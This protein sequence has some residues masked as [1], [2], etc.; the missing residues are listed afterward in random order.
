[1]KK[2]S[3]QYQLFIFLLFSSYFVQA[4]TSN[5]FTNLDISTLSGFSRDLE[6]GCEGGCFSPGDEVSFYV[7]TRLYSGDPS[8]ICPNLPNSFGLTD[9]SYVLNIGE[10]DIIRLN[11][12]RA[13]GTFTSEST[14]NGG[15]F[16][17]TFTFD[18]ITE[19]DFDNNQGVIPGLAE[20]DYCADNEDYG[21][22]CDPQTSNGSCPDN[23]MGNCEPQISRDL[24]FK[25]SYTIPD[26]ATPNTLSIS[27]SETV[28]VFFSDPTTSSAQLDPN[29][30]NIEVNFPEDYQ[31]SPCLTICPAENI[32]ELPIFSRRYLAAFLVFILIAGVYLIKL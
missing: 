5:F 6:G 32:A 13:D 9:I 26:D 27:G 20:I 10:L 31:T 29:N 12:L 21:C 14:D 18:G 2:L 30:T 11:Q 3:N 1:M 4:Q 7:T 15:A 22:D 8:V 19:T 24:V 25:V 16:D 23:A 17:Y 28:S